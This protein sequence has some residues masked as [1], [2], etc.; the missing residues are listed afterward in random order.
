MTLLLRVAA[1]RIRSIGHGS[2]LPRA[3]QRMSP[4]GSWY[5]LKHPW[6]PPSFLIWYLA[7][8]CGRLARSTASMVYDSC[9]WNMQTTRRQ[10]AV[11]PSD[12]RTQTKSSVRALSEAGLCWLCCYIRGMEGATACI[13]LMVISLNCHG[14]P[15]SSLG[16]DAWW[17]WSGCL[18]WK[19]N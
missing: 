4:P 7:W 2:N 9:I 12:V 11:P 5:R 3:Q 17:N 19:T 18:S 10:I 6:C 14:R 8:I 15:A 13:S 1:P 16:C